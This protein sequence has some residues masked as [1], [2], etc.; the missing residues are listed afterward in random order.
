AT[1]MNI[2]VMLERGDL[3]ADFLYRFE[4]R[5]I[6]IPPLRERPADFPAIAYHL[7]RSI[8]RDGSDDR[9]LPWRSV[10]EI[11]SR[12]LAWEG[13][14][15]ELAALLRFVH[16]MTRMPQ[17]REDSTGDLIRFVLARG[18]NQRQWFFRVVRSGFFTGAPSRP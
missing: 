11:F 9:V 13:N 17:H 15:R 3:R 14:V 6:L 10:R 8:T 2:E 4:D 1:N 16:S 18:D 7:W 5:V 12:K